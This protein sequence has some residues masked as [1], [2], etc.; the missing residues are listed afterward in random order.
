M[1]YLSVTSDTYRDLRL[2]NVQNYRF[3]LWCL[4]DVS[5]WPSRKEVFSR[6][7]D[8]C[9]R[10]FRALTVCRTY[11]QYHAPLYLSDSLRSGRC[12]M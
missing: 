12:P 9:K 6:L 11:K 4:L 1:A 3:W 5:L 8:S 10:L 7:A 2:R